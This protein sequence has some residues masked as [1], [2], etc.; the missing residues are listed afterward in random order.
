MSKALERATQQ[1][2]AGQFKKAAD[3]LWEVSFAGD[4]GEAEARALLALAAQLR[5]AAEGGVRADSEE[6]IARA[7][8]YLNAGQRDAASRREAELRR[9]PVELAR[10]A[11]HAG[12]T[13]LAVESAEDLVAA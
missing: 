11:R 12:L 6:H 8:R 4:D 7:E 10:W 2:Q 13:W 9:D 3:T 5:D 1:F